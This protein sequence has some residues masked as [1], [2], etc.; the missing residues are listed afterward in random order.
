L[1]KYHFKQRRPFTKFPRHHLFHQFWLNQKP[2]LRLG[3]IRRRQAKITSCCLYTIVAIAGSALSTRSLTMKT[4]ANPPAAAFSDR[5]Y[6]R[7]WE[8][9]RDAAL[10]M[11]PRI[12]IPCGAN[13]EPLDIF[14]LSDP[15]GPR[16]EEL[17]RRTPNFLWLGL[18]SYPGEVFKVAAGWGGLPRNVAIGARAS[19][20]VEASFGVQWLADL[21][22]RGNPPMLFLVIE[23]PSEKID[24]PTLPGFA[25]LD[26]VIVAG[27]C[28]SRVETRSAQWTRDIRNQCQSNMMVFSLEHPGWPW[29]TGPQPSLDGVVYDDRPTKL[30]D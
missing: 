26:W 16:V 20:Q 28:P 1:V 30:R 22:K 17:I 12:A 23:G 5:A 6:D 9:H 14:D 29:P 18:T 25:A 4:R 19:T 13:G 8:M 7:L 27:Q 11:E 2:F 15:G 10:E 24:L 3:H 21:A